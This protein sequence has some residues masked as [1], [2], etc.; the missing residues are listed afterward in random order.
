MSL[1]MLVSETE[2]EEPGF[3][4]SMATITTIFGNNKRSRNN[5]NSFPSLPQGRSSLSFLFGHILTCRG[6]HHHKKAPR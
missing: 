4:K 5:F 1:A 6:N 3:N 2:E